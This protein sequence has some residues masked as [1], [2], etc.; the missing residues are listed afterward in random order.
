MQYRYPL[1]PPDFAIPLAKI[2]II[3][4]PN[5]LFLVLSSFFKQ[6]HVYLFV[7]VPAKNTSIT[8]HFS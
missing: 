6:L 7:R 8:G 3:H 2:D 5:V 1:R 4:R